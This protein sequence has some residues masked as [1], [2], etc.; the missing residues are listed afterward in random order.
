MESI[1]WLRGKNTD[2]SEE[3]EDMT[4]LFMW[5]NNSVG[6]SRQGY[7]NDT[8]NR[9]GAFYQFMHNVSRFER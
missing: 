2:I 3:Y 4:D 1:Q 7:M 5:G 9:K 6:T 8:I